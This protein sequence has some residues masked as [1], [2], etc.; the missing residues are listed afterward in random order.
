[1]SFI[2]S[3]ITRDAIIEYLQSAK[4]EDLE[5][6]W[7]DYVTEQWNNTKDPKYAYITLAHMPSAIDDCVTVYD[8]GGLNSE[9][10]DGISTIQIKVRNTDYVK[11]YGAAQ[12]IKAMLEGLT[13]YSDK[14]SYWATIGDIN[15]LNGSDENGV[16]EQDRYNCTLNMRVH[17]RNQL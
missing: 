5:E 11:C 8:T 10:G 6:T 4:W 12:E 13:D 1:M 9:A 17:K 16:T 15:N 3:D 7:G 2:P 14:I